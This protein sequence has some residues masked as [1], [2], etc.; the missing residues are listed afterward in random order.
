MW[1]SVCHVGGLQPSAFVFES[2]VP[3]LWGDISPGVHVEQ[4]V[5]PHQTP[6]SD[7]GSQEIYFFLWWLWFCPH[8][9]FV[10]ILLEADAARSTQVLVFGSLLFAKW[11]LNGCP[12][13]P[14]GLRR[15]RE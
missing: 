15:F 8:P 4:P 6:G 5:M 2:S 13:L 9:G 3:S 10:E 7:P 1:Y 11:I 12:G 14:V